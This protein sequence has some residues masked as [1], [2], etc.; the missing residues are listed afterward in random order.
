MSSVTSSLTLP[1]N[2]PFAGTCMNVT[3]RDFVNLVELIPADQLLEWLHDYYEKVCLLIAQTG[4]E[5]MSINNHTLQAVFPANS[6]ANPHQRNAVQCALGILLVVYQA[7]F[8]I[9]KKF[10]Q[11]DLH[12]FEVRIGLDCGEMV[13]AEFGIKPYLNLVLNGQ[14]AHIAAMLPSKAKNLGWK[15]MATQRVIDGAGFG[16]SCRHSE[17]LGEHW[18]KNALLVTEVVH[19]EGVAD[20]P[21][22]EALSI[23]AVLPAFA[24]VSHAEV[25]VF[26]PGYR[27]MRLLGTGAM[28]RVYLAQHLRDDVSVAIKL[29]I[30]KA[31]QDVEVLYR[32]IEECS[33]L[34]RITHP[35][36]VH[37]YE[38]GITDDALFLVMEYLPNGSL[39]ERIAPQGMAL[40]AAWK[41]LR[42]ITEALVEIHRK[43]IFHRDI[44]PENILF[45]SDDRAAL[46]DFGIA[47]IGGLANRTVPHGTQRVYGSPNFMS[48][49]QAAGKKI[50]GRGDV[51]SLG[52]VFYFMLTGRRP[53]LATTLSALIYEHL[54]ADIPTL[55]VK[56]QYLQAMLNS[57][58][59]KHETDRIDAV[60]LSDKLSEMDMRAMTL[61]EFG[62]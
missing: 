2:Q 34:E 48:P 7:R 6:T 23:A 20:V 10:P 13:V 54:H 28:G 19:I 46:S 56:Y 37:I 61:A 35:N 50:D 39:R 57:M 29:T 42:E 18:L 21:Q 8:S 40:L 11:Y 47:Y 45:R 16:V 9:Q 43:K 1:L 22:T 38:Q 26:A 5:V 52:C 30:G 53:Y 58:L 32:Y 25:A 62:E 31:S 41:V 33:V 51:Y 60:A 15:I 36:V 24:D 44:K 12:E 55:P 3:I 14:A 27:I 49:E 17:V 59:A 4:G